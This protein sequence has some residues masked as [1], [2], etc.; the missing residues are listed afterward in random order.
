MSL[1]GVVPPKVRTNH[2]T[3]PSDRRRRG[4]VPTVIRKRCRDIP[5]ERQAV[6]RGLLV[7]I[8]R[9]YP[10][11]LKS[12]SREG[13]SMRISQRIKKKFLIF[14]VFMPVS[15]RFSH[16][17]HPLHCQVYK[18][19]SIKILRYILRCNKNYSHFDHD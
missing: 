19:S 17:L 9:H 8:V 2:G 4:S 10:A 13:A 3:T 15:Y 11:V 7:G 5:A 1:R 6:H 18:F 16:I 12:E 14:I